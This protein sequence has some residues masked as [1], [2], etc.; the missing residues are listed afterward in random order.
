LN[1]GSGIG[2]YGGLS[3]QTA[4]SSDLFFGARLSYDSRSLIAR[5]DQTY[6][7]PDGSFLSDEYSFKNSF[8]SL[9]PHVKFYLGRRFHVTGGL[10]M[11]LVLNQTY[12]YTPEGG[13]PRAGLEVGPADTLKHSITWSGFAGLGYDLYLTDSS[14]DQQLIRSQVRIV[15]VEKIVERVRVEIRTV[16]ERIDTSIGRVDE[17]QGGLESGLGILKTIRGQP[18]D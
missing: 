10:G 2:L 3:F 12:D 9:E 14:A 7:K 13:T 8:V 5:D 11:G 18:L 15:R 16:R 4:V 1:D 17:I 6:A